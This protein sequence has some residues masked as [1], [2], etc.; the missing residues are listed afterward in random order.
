MANITAQRARE[1]VEAATP[2]PWTS[3]VRD[4]IRYVDAP[5][6]G[7]GANTVCEAFSRGADASPAAA[8]PDLART[9]IALEAERDALRAAVREY[10]A[11]LDASDESEA[12]VRRSARHVERANEAYEHM[13]AALAALREAA[14]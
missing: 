8:A 11:A 7:G 4:S 9:V 1:L 5:R 13:S 6:Y 12:D 2:G 10:V 3:R 14:K